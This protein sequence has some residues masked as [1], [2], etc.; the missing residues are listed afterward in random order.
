MPSFLTPHLAATLHRAPHPVPEPL[1]PHTADITVT[2]PAEGGPW[3]GLLR[4]LVEAGHVVRD[5]P[6]P[7]TIREFVLDQVAAVPRDT[8]RRQ[9]LRRDY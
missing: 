1:G 4:P 9:G 2:P 8:L 5:L 7:R 3:E 6:P